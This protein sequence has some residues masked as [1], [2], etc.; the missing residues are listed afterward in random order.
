MK[1]GRQALAALLIVLAGCGSGLPGPSVSEPIASPSQA[2]PVVTPD[3][4]PSI[5]TAS[6]GASVSR[7]P[8]APPR[9]SGEPIGTVR[10]PFAGREM[11]VAIVGQRG[12]VEAWR[13]ATEV[14]LGAVA[15][16]ENAGI[17]LAPVS[18]REL[19]LGWIGTV[20]D[21]EATLIVAPGSLV[22][23]PA[24]REGCDAMAVGRGIVLTYETRVD[25][26]DVEVRLTETVLLPESS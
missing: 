21:V 13:G 11:E 3:V 10:F 7:S 1:A 24:P 12:L 15:W 25:P 17:G 2:S 22:V 4:S 19:V 23:S 20:C 8:S 14:E 5:T 9:P 26:A 16:D 6:P 18:D